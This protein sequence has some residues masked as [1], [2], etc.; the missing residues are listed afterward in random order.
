VLAG[1]G[2]EVRRIATAVDCTVGGRRCYDDVAV[3]SDGVD[4]WSRQGL[5]AE[6]EGR[7]GIYGGGLDLAKGLGFRG[8]RLDPTAAEVPCLSWALQ[9]G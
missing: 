8:H 5:G 1:D 6:R 7:L 3:D 9:E 4:A 2:G